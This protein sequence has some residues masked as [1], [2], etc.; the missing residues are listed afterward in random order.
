MD[1]NNSEKL[2]TGARN[3]KAKGYTPKQVDLWLK[4]KG[5][6]LEQLK[7]FAADNTRKL[8]ITDEQ[9]EFIRK[10]NEAYSERQ[11][12]AQ[13]GLLNPDFRP[14]VAAMQGIA[15]SGLNPFGYI[16]RSAGI[17]TKPFK[18]ETAT[19]RGIE[20]GI[21][22][23]YDAAVL[24]SLLR[25]GLAKG[26]TMPGFLGNISRAV[27]QA[28]AGAKNSSGLAKFAHT[29]LAPRVGEAALTA[30]GGG[31][32]AGLVNSQNPLSDFLLEITGGGLAGIGNMV[33]K[34]VGKSLVNST[35]RQLG[36]REL[37]NQLRQGEKFQDIDMGHISNDR[38]NKINEIRRMNG[39]ED[40][41]NS[42]VVIPADRVGHIYQ[43]RIKTDGW[44]PKQV[45]D[46]VYNAVFNKNSQASKSDY[47]TLTALVNIGKDK[48]DIGL[49]GKIRDGNNIFVKTGMKKNTGNALRKFPDI[50][51]KASDGRRI[52][53]SD[54]AGSTPTFYSSKPY[55]ASD[56]SNINS[57]SDVN[58]RVNPVYSRSF[59]EALADRDKARTMRN[60]VMSGA[61]ELAENARF[62][63]D[64]L[65]RRKDGMFDAD[66]E[67]KLRTP[68]M[69][70]AERAYGK[71]MDEY[72]DAVLS[73]DK[74]DNFYSQHPVAQNVINEM[75]EVDPRAFD[76]IQ[77]GSLKELDMLKKILREEAGNKTY[78]GASKAGAL[79]RAE[80]DLKN[81]MDNEFEGFRNVNQQYANA[82]TTQDLFESKLNSG[83]S[84]VGGATVSP[85]WSGISSPLASAGVVGSF[86]SPE[87]LVFA[88]GG[89]GG[90]A[91]LR[92]SRR[93]T[94]RALAQGLTPVS[95][96]IADEFKMG[97]IEALNA[98]KRQALLK[99]I[100]DYDKH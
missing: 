89:L 56:I 27:A 73:S 30:G 19:E 54:P 26:V 15:N 53:S 63:K 51:N 84:S 43:K 4:S 29:V 99:A 71:F 18:A 81:L 78:A 2:L 85:F 58:S 83:L 61:D 77:S 94:G 74:I 97:G 10:N 57:I 37:I 52:P 48:S 41:S 64:Q 72:G 24:A 34:Q 35:K 13:K 1:I 22:T 36:K 46:T 82:K 90:K 47:D 68:E 92:A 79:K 88:L 8:N 45:A 76:G 3:L 44:S 66:L 95:A 23:A 39:L 98:M 80:N 59:I 12:K 20:R 60:A 93:N 28:G 16:A 55:Y 75:R 14:V 6:S 70:Q 17:D 96:K 40:I 86:I 21:G 49:V 69:V 38:L 67:R 42:Q 25:S 87:A 31:G 9:K 7:S 91:A 33:G 11:K 100:E 32:L 62:L 50:S 65:A 5:S